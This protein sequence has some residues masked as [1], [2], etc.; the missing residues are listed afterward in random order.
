LPTG[1]RQC[2]RQLTY[3]ITNAA[4]F[5]AR[6]RRILGGNKDYLLVRDD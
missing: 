6:E 5:S 4:D 1:V 2:S 3:D